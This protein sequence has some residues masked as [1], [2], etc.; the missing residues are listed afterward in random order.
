[1]LTFGLDLTIPQS[2]VE[3]CMLLA[4]P[5]YEA[6]SLVNDIYSWPKERADAA[7]SGQDYVF[8]AVWVIMRERDCDE[9]SALRICRDMTLQLLRKYEHIMD[10]LKNHGLSP[11]S[12]QYLEAVRQSY[13][14]NLVWSIYCP[15]Y[16]N[17]ECRP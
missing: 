10:G 3:T 17:D 11:Q 14:G 13:V 6:I 8:N 7:S 16:N 12:R 9:A 5:A 1:M 2:E 15:R 4:R